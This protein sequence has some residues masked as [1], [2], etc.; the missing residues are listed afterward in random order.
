MR[1]NN[2]NN[3]DLLFF[4][5]LSYDQFFKIFSLQTSATGGSHSFIWSTGRMPLTTMSALLHTNVGMTSPGQSHSS[6]SW[7]R[8]M[9]CNT[10][11]IVAFKKTKDLKIVSV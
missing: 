8:Y 5:K 2:F 11:Y 10:K 4:Y 1:K 3:I 6:R 7:S 9:V